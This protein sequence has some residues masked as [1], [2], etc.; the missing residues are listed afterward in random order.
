MEF[1]YP[2]HPTFREI[3]TYV[4][5]CPGTRVRLVSLSDRKYRGNGTVVS[6]TLDGAEIKF[7]KKQYKLGKEN[8]L[9]MSLN[10]FVREDQPLL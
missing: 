3:L 8:I 10:T 2:S 5:C 7:D 6:I 4:T 1:Y 9:W